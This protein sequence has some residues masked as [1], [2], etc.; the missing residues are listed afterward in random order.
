MDEREDI[1][2]LGSEISGSAASLRFGIA[3]SFS[4]P[5]EAKQLAAF[6]GSNMLVILG[7]ILASIGVVAILAIMV[8]A[9]PRMLKLP[10]ADHKPLRE[11]AVKERIIRERLHRKLDQWLVDVQRRT[12]ALF[13]GWGSA[14]D[15]AYRRLRLLAQEYV[16][17]K[18]GAVAT[19]CASAIA[20]A[21]AALAEGAYDHAEERYLACLKIDAKHRE[22]YRGLA[23]LYRARREEALASETY[24]FL[25]KLYPDDAEI[26]F[27]YAELLKEQEKYAAA[28]KEMQHALTLAPRNPK[29]L[30]FA[31]AL[32]IAS[33]KRIQATRW[34]RA[35]E[36]ANPENK[37]LADFE[38]QIV[39]MEE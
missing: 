8:R 28:I 15:R 27:E 37:K 29:Y 22:A 30:D 21:G 1:P 4:P 17:T 35:F 14:L 6:V 9:L 23:T 7:I 34:L 11:R 10:A 32:A 26:A 25:R 12:R 5:H 13:H 16:A 2:F 3:S 19:T 20:E 18:P 39:E 38:R 36:E 24:A 31:I 33:R